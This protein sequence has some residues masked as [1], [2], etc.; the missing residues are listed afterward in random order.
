MPNKDPE[1]A[2]VAS[3]EAALADESTDH[4]AADYD[5]DQA[6]GRERTEVEQVLVWPGASDAFPEGHFVHRVLDHNPE[7]GPD[8]AEEDTTPRGGLSTGER[9][10][11]DG[12]RPPARDQFQSSS[13]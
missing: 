12:C 10:A 3:I 6:D 11:P 7:H 8:V 1:A 5:H 4:R 9:G 13:F 2:A